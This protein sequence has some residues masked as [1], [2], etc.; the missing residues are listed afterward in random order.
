MEVLKK[1]FDGLRFI[2]NWKGI[3]EITSLES[4]EV[5]TLN[6]YNEESILFI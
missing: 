3:E 4:R 2:I 1:M 5:Y 6:D